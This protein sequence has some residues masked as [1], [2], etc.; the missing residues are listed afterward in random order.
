M[1]LLKKTWDKCLGMA[2]KVKARLMKTKLF[3]RLILLALL[4]L[5]GIYGV[6]G[7]IVGFY[8]KEGIVNR[9]L[10]NEQY[11]VKLS[12]LEKEIKTLKGQLSK[13]IPSSNYLIINT[14][15]NEFTLMKGTDIIKTGT[16]STGSYIRL[17]TGSGRQWLFRT[18]RGVFSIKGKIVDPV[19]R[20]P[21]WAFIE[22]GLPVPPPDHPSRYEPGVL[23]D[24]ALLL[25]RGYLIHG[26]LY[27][28]FL[29]L[30]VTHGCIRLNDENLKLVYKSLNVGSKVYIF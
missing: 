29:G 25:G 10:G 19:W 17:K 22:E 5:A 1:T 15:A 6:S 4:S 9:V 13:K 16:C 30:P 2:L 28:R 7:Y 12:Q 11:T 23:G 24:Y 8:L 21:D 27:Q 18:P 26:T 3:A 20:K 14:S